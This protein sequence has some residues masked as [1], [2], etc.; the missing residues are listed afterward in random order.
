LLFISASHLQ[1]AEL[2]T[3]NFSY[4]GPLTASGWVAHSAAGSKTILAD[5]N[6][7]TLRQGAG[8][9]E[10]VNLS[11]TPQ[12][13]SDKT[14]VLFHI[15]VL[16]TASIA[17]GDLDANGLYFAHFKDAATNFP[18]RVFITNPVSGGD[19]SFGIE[20]NDSS[21]DKVWASDFSFDTTQRVVMA[22]DAANGKAELWVNPASEGS[23]KLITA[24]ASTGHLVESFALRQSSD[25]T[26]DQRIDNVVV[27]TDFDSVFFVWDGSVGDW[28]DDTRWLGGV[29]PT[30]NDDVTINSGTVRVTLG[31]E[32]ARRIDQHGG[33]LNIDGGNLTTDIGGDAGLAINSTM[34]IINSGAVD[35]YLM[36]IGD[37]TDGSL[38]L[39]GASSQMTVRSPSGSSAEVAIGF[40]NNTTGTMSVTN[41]ATFLYNPSNGATNNVIN[42]ASGS[43]SGGPDLVNDDGSRLTISGIGSTVEL[44]GNLLNVGKLDDGHLRITDGGTLRTGLG[45]IAD[46]IDAAGSSAIVSGAG[47]QWIITNGSIAGNIAVGQLAQGSLRVEN[48]GLVSVEGFMTIAERNTAGLST[49]TVTGIGSS[50]MVGGGGICRR[51]LRWYPWQS[52]P[53]IHLGWCDRRHRGA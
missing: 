28:D 10:D 48:G 51:R 14:Y 52:R 8:A 15:N 6:T 21:V 2:V 4:T 31:G 1:A 18:G 45:V 39:D 12:G 7:A 44:S 29:E 40:N 35:T 19:F 26:G 24:N 20:A 23:T 9:G 47:S 32:F 16:S 11:F 13:A 53:L 33:T 25:F 36:R 22:Y 41:G 3:D 38:V 42:V 27:G 17:N 49:V 50:M 37:G 43:G 46:E 34:N 5:G 30:I